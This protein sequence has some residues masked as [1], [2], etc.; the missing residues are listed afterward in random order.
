[1][2]FNLW[3][4]YVWN[5]VDV[6]RCDAIHVAYIFFFAYA[7]TYLFPYNVKSVGT[8]QHFTYAIATANAN[9]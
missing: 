5:N 9:N 1:M 7:P 3:K 6:D 4:I 8:V 2:E